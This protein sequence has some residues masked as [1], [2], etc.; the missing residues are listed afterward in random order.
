MS[1]AVGSN[2]PICDIMYAQDHDCFVRR[3]QP[4]AP[5]RAKYKLLK[6]D[7]DGCQT[8]PSAWSVGD[9]GEAD[10][11]SLN[12][13]DVSR[14]TGYDLNN[15]YRYRMMVSRFMEWSPSCSSVVESFQGQK[16]SFSSLQ[17]QYKILFGI[18]IASFA[19]S[20]ICIF[21]EAIGAAQLFMN[22][23]MHF[24]SK[25]TL[26]KI[27]FP[28]R[29]G[30]WILVAPSIIIVTSQSVQLWRSFLSI[31]DLSCSDA[32]SNKFLTQIGQTISDNLG[33][34][35]TIMIVLSFVEMGIEIILALVI[36]IKYGQIS[37]CCKFQWTV[38]EPAPQPAAQPRQ[39]V[40]PP[41]K[42]M[43]AQPKSLEFE[44]LK[45]VGKPELKALP[46]ITDTR[47]K[48]SDAL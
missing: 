31:A 30:A 26:L 36:L 38:A 10:F 32:D 13:I 6:G 4:L 7:F 28:I 15:N 45:G 17:Q 19:I 23:F 12:N 27:F 33:R 46:T 14:L 8:D 24:S 21:G 40:V 9:M 34:K 22:S 1:S 43:I 11:F 25:G 18:Y 3:Q 41:P 39:E 48:H 16:N 42:Q 44:G 29:L 20:I 2:N 47:R 5:G 37:C 35:N